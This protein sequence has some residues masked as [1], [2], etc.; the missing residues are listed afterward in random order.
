[1]LKFI[2][3]S[4]PLVYFL[5]VFLGQIHA[6][7]SR[8]FSFVSFLAFSLKFLCTRSVSVESSRLCFS[9]GWAASVAFGSGVCMRREAVDATN[10]PLV[11]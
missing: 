8:V 11:A 4:L 1:M 6:K 3:S 9:F 7:V 5:R 10:I 2:M